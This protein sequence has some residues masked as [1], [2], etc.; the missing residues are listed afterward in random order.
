MKGPKTSPMQLLQRRFD[1]RP[2]RVSEA[3]AAGVS[4]TTLHRLRQNGELETA[5]R[6]VL[7]LP[8]SGMGM[9]SELAVV[10]TRAPGATICLNS[11]LA[12]WD[13]TDEIPRR[14]HIAVPRGTHR[15]HID[16]P[17]TKVH[18]FNARTY[19]VDRQ[20]AQTDANEPF[21]IYSP[22]RSVVDAMRMG[23]WIGHDVALHALRRYLSRPD[24]EPARL[25]ELARQLGGGARLQ[26]ALEAL[27]S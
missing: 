12:F 21:W 7:R 16:R 10:S 17:A 19:G 6:G 4:N 9:L 20:R 26:P 24:A 22:E 18:V 5:G 25:S 13:L 11:A 1:E 15:P 14:I 8:E 23:R 27:L 3:I 2:F